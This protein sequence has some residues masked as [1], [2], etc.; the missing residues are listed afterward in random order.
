MRSRVDD[1]KVEPEVAHDRTVSRWAPAERVRT[2]VTRAT[3]A[4]RAA[5]VRRAFSGGDAVRLMM[6]RRG[7]SERGRPSRAKGRQ[8]QDGEAVP[9][10]A[11]RGRRHGD[12]ARHPMIGVGDAADGVDDGVGAALDDGVSPRSVVG[13]DASAPGAAPFSAPMSMESSR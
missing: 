13:A 7:I 2:A 8:D 3:A 6:E 1:S 9:L 12:A 10:K 4:T 5:R 11:T